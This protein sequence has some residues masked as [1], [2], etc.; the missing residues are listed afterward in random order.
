M[1][2]GGAETR[3]PHHGRERRLDLCLQRKQWERS[4]RNSVCGKWE[5]TAI[6]VSGARC[7]RSSRT[8]SPFP[9]VAFARRLGWP[10]C[11]SRPIAYCARCLAMSCGVTRPNLPPKCAIT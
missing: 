5:K 8:S 3:R 2:A 7:K 6:Q 10:T 9:A 1:N 11:C 4:A